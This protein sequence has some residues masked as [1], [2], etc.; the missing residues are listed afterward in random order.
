MKNKGIWIFYLIVIA[1]VI[2]VTYPL[3][4]RFVDW[5]TAS[6]VAVTGFSSE[7]TGNVM[8]F[9]ALMAYVL[10]L[11][12]IGSFLGL[13]PYPSQLVKTYGWVKVMI[14]LVALSALLLFAIYLVL[15]VATIAAAIF[16]VFMAIGDVTEDNRVAEDPREE[17]RRQNAYN[18]EMRLIT[19]AGEKRRLEEEAIAARRAGDYE[20][21]TRFQ[22]DAD[23]L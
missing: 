21:A 10:A 14:G 13:Y 20:R 22:N 2:Y 16:L 9:L 19:L 3:T 17:V 5:S 15:I 12:S 18:E 4:N 1:L 7:A 6:V 8:S 23:R 11:G